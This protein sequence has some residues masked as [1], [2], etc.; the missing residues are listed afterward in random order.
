MTCQK[1]AIPAL[2]EQDFIA[3][4]YPLYNIV[5]LKLSMKVI[6]MKP[7]TEVFDR[8]HPKC[9]ILKQCTGVRVQL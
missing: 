1:F 4:V 6:I 9:V 2:Y 5:I 7:C 3:L 8:Y